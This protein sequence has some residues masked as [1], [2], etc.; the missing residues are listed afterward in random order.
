MKFIIGFLTVL[1]CVLGGYVLHHGKLSVLW[2][3]TEFLIILGAAVGSFI[4]GTPGSG[5]KDTLKS[6]KYLFKGMPYSKADYTELLVMLNMTFK[7]MRAK[8]MLEIESH[9]ETPESS[10]IF[11]LAPKFLNNHAAVHF[12][13]DYLRVMTMGMED[14]YQLDDMMEADLEI[15]RA[16][17]GHIAHGVVNLAD[18]MPALGIVAAVLGVIVTMG[19]IT[20][21]PEILGGLI[22]AALVGTFLG[23]L[24]SYGFV[25]PMGRYIGEYFA[26]DVKYI[27]VIK[28]ALLAH[29]KGNAPVISV[30]IARNT[31][32]EHERPSF[33]ELEESLAATPSV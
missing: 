22:G 31:I 3:P 28:A 4:I 27:E 21:P 32:G 18:A 11:Q 29:V 10:S 25:A 8:G 16:H 33:K 23:V 19:S 5:I 13:C 6:L 7:T 14:Q 20:E 2:Q 15:H 17:G 1:G 12:L 26:A 24:V 30:E 9:I